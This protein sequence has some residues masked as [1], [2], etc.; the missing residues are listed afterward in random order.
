[1]EHIANEVERSRKAGSGRRFCRE[2]LE[3]SRNGMCRKRSR[4]AKEADIGVAC[5]RGEGLLFAGGKTLRKV[6]EDEIVSELLK[7]AGEYTGSDN[8]KDSD[9]IDRFLQIGGFH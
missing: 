1:M 2:R 4:R 9:R 8:E 5:G 6:K 3:D 7:L